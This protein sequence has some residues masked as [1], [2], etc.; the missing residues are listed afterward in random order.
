M[1][2]CKEPH[3]AFRPVQRSWGVSSDSQ[4]QARQRA[5]RQL[6]ARYTARRLG[7]P[8]SCAM[9]RRSSMRHLPSSR[10]VNSTKSMGAPPPPLPP[11]LGERLMEAAG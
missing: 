10:T 11:S 3:G 7:L 1:Y 8:D 4:A 9:R 6:T 2:I 5:Q